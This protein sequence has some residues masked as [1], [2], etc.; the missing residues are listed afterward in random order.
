MQIKDMTYDYRKIVG[1]L[2][3]WFDENARVLPWRSNPRPYY[4]WVSEIMLQ[5]TRVEAVKEYFKRFISELPDIRALAQVDEDRL[6][7]LWEGLGYYNRARNLKKAA[8]TVVEQY[9]G[10]LPADEKALLSLSGIGS[11]TAGAISAI[12][13]ELPV[14]A[15]DGNV[16]RVAMRLT[17]SD[18]DIA[19]PGVKKELETVLRAV[20]EEETAGREGFSNGKFNQ[21]LMELGATVCIPNG[22]PLCGKCPLKSHCLALEKN[23]VMELPVKAAKKARRIEDKTV[24]IL[25]Y[26]D[27]YAL[28]KRPE[29]G[30][31][32]GLWEFPNLEGR[33]PIQEVEALMEQ[34]EAPDYEMEL[35]GDAKHIFSHVEWH[36]LGYKIH[37]NQLSSQAQLKKDR[38]LVW[39]KKVQ[40][41]KE[42]ALPSAFSVY[43][44]KI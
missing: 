43:R 9:G 27:C 10:E 6:L 38:D 19:K 36:M 20:M 16:L 26:Q 39:V 8:C 30:L 41:E 28:H 22:K 37:L 13:F 42:Y 21:A 5:Q 31:L 17:A 44:K 24:L 11:Y 18:A 32:S 2:L 40:M 4:V 25:E 23:I 35:L 3:E 7:K 29:K 12:A 15:V 14:P 34:L 1:E 33:L